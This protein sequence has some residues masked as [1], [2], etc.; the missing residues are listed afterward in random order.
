MFYELVP[1]V[2]STFDVEA[3][4]TLVANRRAFVA[5]QYPVRVVKLCDVCITFLEGQ[6]I[7]LLSVDTEGHDM[8]VLR[9]LD[10]TVNRPRLIV[11]ETNRMEASAVYEEVHHYLITR[12]Y[13][14]IHTVGC[15]ALYETDV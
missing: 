10:L 13:R 3:V 1:R 15:N 6:Q 14:H 4:E 11:C 8:A 12:S 5:A 7:D 9:G 2:L